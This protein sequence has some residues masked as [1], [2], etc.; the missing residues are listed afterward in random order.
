M[1]TKERLE[2]AHWVA[3]TA[4]RAGADDAAVDISNSRAV[5]TEFRDGKLDRVKESTQ[6][7]LNISLYVDSQFSGH[8]TNDL[9]RESL[10]SFIKKTVC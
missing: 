6:N 5:E 7:S 2:L 9:R 10:E 8:S 3:N 4:M 1:N